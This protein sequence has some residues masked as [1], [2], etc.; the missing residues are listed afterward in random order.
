MLNRRSLL[1][2]QNTRECDKIR[3]PV[4][5]NTHNA[6]LL[7][8]TSYGAQIVYKLGESKDEFTT[9]A[10]AV[11]MGQKGMPTNDLDELS[12]IVIVCQPAEQELHYVRPQQKIVHEES[13]CLVDHDKQ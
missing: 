5:S 13:A 10:L 1:Q 6:C 3:G 8:G 12:K 11:L 9:S 7:I 4:R 2:D